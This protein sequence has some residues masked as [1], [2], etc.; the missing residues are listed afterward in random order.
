MSCGVTVGA[1]KN[2]TGSAMAFLRKVKPEPYLQS[3]SG[4]KCL[5]HIRHFACSETGRAETKIISLIWLKKCF[6]QKHAFYF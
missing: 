5:M 1:G 3:I 4:R 2:R 6:P